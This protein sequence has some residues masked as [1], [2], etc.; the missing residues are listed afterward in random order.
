MHIFCWTDTPVNVSEIKRE[1]RNIVCPQFITKSHGWQ[2]LLQ[3]IA[4]EPDLNK[5]KA[6]PKSTH[7][8]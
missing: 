8:E 6:K 3:H 4:D 5:L 2:K 7:V 1:K